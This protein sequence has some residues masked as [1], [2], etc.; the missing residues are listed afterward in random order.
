MSAYPRIA[1]LAQADPN[2][3]TSRQVQV[4]VIHQDCEKPAR[5]SMHQVDKDARMAAA[6][7]ALLAHI[8]ELYGEADQLRQTTRHHQDRHADAARLLEKARAEVTQIAI[9]TSPAY[10]QLRDERDSARRE[11]D[12][13]M[14]KQEP[15]RVSVVAALAVLDSF[16]TL[17]ADDFQTEAL[18]DR[19]RNF[20][21]GVR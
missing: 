19:A 17:P 13:A 11:R 9:D 1:Q 7:P 2:K 16:D 3:L 18:I 21:R 15:L 6:V 4:H 12:E 5:G 10:A 20:L 14:R 8:D